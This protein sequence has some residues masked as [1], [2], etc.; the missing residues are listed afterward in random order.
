MTTTA[1]GELAPHFAL[2]GLDG[3]EYSL[4]S[5]AE[6]EPVLIVFFRVKCVTCD[7]AFPYINR[8][9]EAYPDGWRL[10]TVSQ[11]EPDTTAAYRDRF[12]ITAPVLLD[13]PELGVSRLYDP[14]STPSWFLAGPDGRV[15]FTFD[16]FDKADINHLSER[17]AAYTG[18]ARVEIAQDDDGA[19]AMKPG[20]M[21]RHLF[22]AR[23]G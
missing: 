7:V 17:I 21:S 15:E 1:V 9:R 8:L 11:D 13:A 2:L 5:S 16:G 19:P 23:R 3:R 6:G 20:C 12:G 14:P 18:T 22:P 4:P 10:W